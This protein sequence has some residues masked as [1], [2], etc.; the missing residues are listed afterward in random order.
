MNR[1]R[2]V[3]GV[4]FLLYLCVG[5]AAAQKNYLA[6]TAEWRAKREAGLKTEG[7][8][9]TVVGLFWL[10]DGVNT[11][12]RGDGFDI[13]LTD[14]FKGDKFGEI[15]FRDGKAVLTVAPGV[16]ATSNEKPF[17]SGELVSDELGKQ[18]IIK[19][20]T[21]S[22]YLINREGRFGIRLKDSDSEA[23]RNF[24]HLDWYPVDKK[25]RV[26]ARFEKY[27]K[28]KDVLIPNILGGTFKMQAPGL[29]K[30]KLNGRQYSVEPVVEE[31]EEDTLFIIFRDQTSRATTYGAGR[32][33]YADMPKGDT[34][35]LDFNKAENPPCAFTSFATCPL[36]PQQNRLDVAIAAGEKRYEHSPGH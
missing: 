11:I 3:L 32:F 19:T 18:T 31:G 26:T 16:E 27:A 21:Q 17:T 36:P 4:A 10:K 22:F 15:D 9:L 2:L 24:T 8:W 13:E 29:L 12:G 30:F 25:Y 23:R 33:L 5:L 14:N 28:P 34:V 20:G 35:V 6:D 1:I 7:G